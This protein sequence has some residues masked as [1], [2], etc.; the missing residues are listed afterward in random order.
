MAFVGV[1]LPVKWT[2]PFWG[3]SFNYGVADSTGCM[4]LADAE[5]GWSGGPPPRPLRVNKPYSQGV[6]RSPD[7]YGARVIT[8]A[9]NVWA[10]DSAS[11]RNAEHKL[12]A[13]FS[14][15]GALYELHCIEETGELLAYCELDGAVTIQQLGLYDF[16]WS[17]QLAAP[18]P[19]KYSAAANSSTTNLPMT[20]G[21]LDWVTGGGLNW[22]TGGGLNW[23]TVTSNGSVIMTNNGTADTW[24]TYTVAAGANALVTPG[25]TITVSGNT[26]FYNNTLAAGDTLVITTNPNS[27]SVILN[28]Q[29][30]RRA[31]LTIAQWASIPANST[32]SATFSSAVYSS[33]ATLTASWANAYW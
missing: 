12:A 31:S 20:T 10:P 8:L 9:G 3:L 27:R 18:D 7:F 5:K 14:D 26:L 28:G 2:M 23:G 29:S 22:V 33:T 6:F 32:V 13:A 17:I 24:P 1:A 25:I 30:D 21:G 11:R 15:P 19:R 16:A 4:W